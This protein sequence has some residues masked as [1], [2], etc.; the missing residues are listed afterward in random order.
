MENARS[1]KRR[2]LG[3]LNIA[4]KEDLEKASVMLKGTVRENLFVLHWDKG[5]IKA[6]LAPPSKV[7]ARKDADSLEK[8]D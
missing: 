7:S 3:A 6:K 1:D 8:R 5:A 2:S 4:D